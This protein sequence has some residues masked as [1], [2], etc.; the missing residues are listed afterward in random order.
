[1]V[2]QQVLVLFVRVR[3][4]LGQLN[5]YCMKHEDLF[6]VIVLSFITLIVGCLIVNGEVPDKPFNKPSVEFIDSEMSYDTIKDVRFL[7]NNYNKQE[8]TCI[9]IDAY[10]RNGTHVMWGRF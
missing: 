8:E 3:I 10:A 7:T 6:F 4:L 1:M 2:A 5:F 9:R